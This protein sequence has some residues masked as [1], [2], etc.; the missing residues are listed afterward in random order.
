[1]GG[2]M[3]MSQ[4]LKTREVLEILNISRDKLRNLERDGLLVPVEKNPRS[5]YFDKEDVT[6]Y[7]NKFVINRL[8]SREVLDILNISRDKL[9]KLERDGL[10]IPVER[11]SHYKYFD[12]DDVMTYLKS[13]QQ[14]LK[15]REVLEILN[16]SHDKL[17][18]LER[19]GFLIPIKKTST[20]KY[21]NRDDVM[22]CLK[23]SERKAKNNIKMEVNVWKM[24]L[25]R[26]YQK[27]V[28]KLIMDKQ[29]VKNNLILLRGKLRELYP[30]ETY[31]YDVTNFMYMR[32]V[33][34][35][36]NSCSN[37]EMSPIIDNDPLLKIID[38]DRNLSDYFLT[39]LDFYAKYNN[40]ILV[41]IIKEL[42]A[43]YIT[44]SNAV[45]SGRIKS[46]EMKPKKL[47]KVKSGSIDIDTNDV[48]WRKQH[49]QLEFQIYT[50]AY[51]KKHG[52]R[53]MFIYFPK[54]K[55]LPEWFCTS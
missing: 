2:V 29:H 54:E 35:Q 22:T 26:S 47:S 45:K 42:N 46:F 14:I 21:F 30:D 9:L 33:L 15:S 7:L 3:I 24:R 40:H 23:E 36:L 49:S 8:K 25:P 19:D 11:D 16:I 53:N 27:F 34:S 50:L 37:E 4:R 1:M 10:L 5:K 43:S 20:T 32:K 51:K 55:L 12:K 13:E 48:K 44:T 39:L 52:S 6:A 38:M 31:Q 28:R 41:D 18:K 17:R